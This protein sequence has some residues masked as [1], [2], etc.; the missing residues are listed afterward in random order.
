MGQTST[1]APQKSQL[2]SSIW[3]PAP[4]AMRVVKPRPGEGDGGGVAE[5]VAG[6]HAAG[7]DDAHLRI[8]FEE[9]V[10]AVGLGLVEAVEG[11]GLVDVGLDVG[12]ADVCG[13][14]GGLQFAAVVL[15]AGH[16]AVGDLVVAEADLAGAAVLNAV[17]G[18]AAVGVVGEDDGEDF[19]AHL[20]HGW[21]CRCG[22]PCRR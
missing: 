22:R 3:P 21:A 9:G 10:G 14:A 11:A 20:D 12:A 7:A 16:A 19:L 2:D 18:E 1:Q 6:A 4:K 13:V 17:A 5:V 8:E 15:G